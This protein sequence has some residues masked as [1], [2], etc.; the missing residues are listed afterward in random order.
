MPISRR[1]GSISKTEGL[2]SQ[3]R[4]QPGSACEECRKRKLRCDRQ[5]PTCGTCAESGIVCEINHNR[6]ARGPKKGDL[7]SLRSRIVA[8]ERRLSL[9]Q[10]AEGLLI[11]DSDLLAGLDELHHHHH[12]SSSEGDAPHLP[13]PPERKLTWDSEIHV[14]LPPTTPAIAPLPLPHFKFPASPPP[15]RKLTPID[16]LMR[17]DLDQLYFDRVHPSVPIFNQSRYFA[18]QARQAGGNDD[19][20]AD[21]R[22][23]LQYA[24]WTL[25]MAL[26]SQF[27]A[28]RT[29]LY[30]ETR[31]MLEALDM[32]EDDVAR[33]RIEQVQA[34]LLIAFYEFARVNFRR[35]WVSA[36]RAFRLV[37]LAKLHEIDSP[38]VGLDGSGDP[39][40]VEERRR[41]FWLAYCLDRF[42]C[43]KSQWP[44]T[45]VE[46]V[47]CTRLPSP[48]IAFQGGHPIQMGF[49]SEAIASP[50]HSLFSPLAEC[51]ILV[52]ICGRTMS[53]S[54]VS[55]VEQAYGNNAPL[56]FWLRHEWLDGLLTRR[57]D[58]LRVN[59]PVVSAVTDS[60]LLFALVL[61]QAAVVYLTSIMDK[62]GGEQ[63]CQPAVLEYRKRAVSAAQE[64][65]R[66]TKAQ[67][68]LGFFKA[69]I[70]LPL[71]ISFGL[72][73]LTPYQ[74]RRRSSADE[75]NATVTA[76][77]G[78]SVLGPGTGMEMAAMHGLDADM[79]TCMEALRKM[80]SFNNLARDFVSPAR[81]EFTGFTFP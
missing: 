41:T 2:P 63:Q 6:L 25:A 40:L 81:D 17:A 16:D 60:M 42:I 29:P 18:Q 69:H 11:G 26:S 52:T 23:C 55:T 9:D 5:R 57:L 8:L 48:E 21:H 46:E 13:S 67:E 19:I 28:S 73:C 59:Y 53:H 49:L 70:F 80:Q 33:V 76:A 31:Q 56:D 37:Q 15:P 1:T 22:T 77:G 39:I 43:M 51:A 71:T 47:I 20:Q 32:A 74:S 45:L 27:E 34:W 10:T 62:L 14:Q 4:Q 7:K 79:Q 12:V 30:N 66:L 68:H 64:I 54:Q 3:P 58:A 78:F 65:A 72:S 44:L 36:G 75:M 50:D 35:G 24:M 61:G 38:G